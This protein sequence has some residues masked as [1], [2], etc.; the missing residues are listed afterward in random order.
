MCDVLA[1]T[2]HSHDFKSEIL[3]RAK[4]S[5]M[6]IKADAQYP[7]RRSNQS[8]AA[9]KAGVCSAIL[10]VANQL[11]SFSQRGIHGGL[12]NVL[13]SRS[14]IGCCQNFDAQPVLEPS[15]FHRRRQLT[16]HLLRPQSRSSHG[17]AGMAASRVHVRQYM[18]PAQR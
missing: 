8:T 6:S 11:E 10:D 3:A 13:F 16:L 4:Q 17:C 15:S 7:R 1:N 14:V 5:R 12:L 2:N 9:T 18:M